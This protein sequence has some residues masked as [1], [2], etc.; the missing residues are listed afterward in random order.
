M[1]VLVQQINAL[2]YKINTM[3]T[4]VSMPPVTCVSLDEERARLS[5]RL[6]G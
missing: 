5:R 3:G 4:G 1:A 6:A 2:V